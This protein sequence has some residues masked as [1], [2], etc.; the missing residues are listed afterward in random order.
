MAQNR[1][2]IIAEAGVNHNG[3]FEKALK[4]VDAAVE[5]GVDIVKFQTFNASKLISRFAQKAEYQKKTT[6]SAESQLE[7]VQKLE[8]SRD[9]HFKLKERAE[10]GGIE[11]LS[12]GFD[13]ES[14]DFLVHEVG[15]KR[16]KIPSGEITNAPFLL[17]M[18]QY[19]LPIILST[20]MANLGEIEAALSVIAFGL[21][22]S[23]SSNPSRVAFAEALSSAEGKAALQKYVSILHCTTE[24]PAPVSEVNLLAMGGMHHAF[25]L[26]TGYSDHTLGIAVPT[27]AV[28]LGATIIEKHFTLDK[29]L[30]GPDHSASL[31]PHELK[32]M[33]DS[34]RTV[35]QALG[36]SFKCP[37]ISEQKNKIPARKSLVAGKSIQK[38]EI[39][40]ELNL[41]MKRPGSGRTPF[42]FWNLIGIKASRNYAPDEV[43][44]D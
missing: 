11:F 6:G 24:Y 42:D 43:I 16:I 13:I 37:T 36:H 33:V 18:A 44:H 20:G 1:C 9:A 15:I 5:A 32:G 17:K 31:E 38:D 4:L 40:T 10:S 34:V 8:L 22:S 26:P 28:A 23:T 7:M 25:G 41:E 30:P 27:A 35:E 19:K 3:S 12:T 21:I 29:T 39:F 14:L 2:L